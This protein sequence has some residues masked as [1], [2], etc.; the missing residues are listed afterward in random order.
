[1][2]TQLRS[3]EV[4]AA[5]RL[6]LS[7]LLGSMA[8]VELLSGIIQGYLVPLLPSLGEQ[9]DITSAGQARIYLLSQLAFAVWTPLL[10]KLGDAYGYRRLLRV[11]IAVVAAGSLLMA[12]WPNSATLA[13]GVVLQAAVVGFMPLLIGILRYQTPQRRRSGTGLL[14]G[15]LT[16]AVGLGGVFS[17]VLSEHTATLGLWVA[18]PVAVLA[19]A[20]GLLLP[21]G[22]PRQAGSMPWPAFLLM[23]LG[24]VGVVTA[25]SQGPSWGWASFGTVGSFVGGLVACAGWILVES[26]ART[27]LV[28]LRMLADPPVAIVSGVTFCLAFCTIGFFGANSVFLGSSPGQDGFGLSY[29]PLAIALVTLMLNVFAL[30]SSL[31]TA[32]LLRKLGERYTLAL[33][34]IV[35][36]TCFVSLLLWH[37]STTQYLVAIALLGIGFGGYQASTRT[38]CV[39][40]V[41]EKDTAMAAGINELALSLGSACGSAMVGAIMSAHESAGGMSVHAFTWLWSVLALVAIAG[42]GLGLRYRTREVIQ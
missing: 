31:S 6:P 41:P 39:E 32:R 36:A 17:G 11:S 10:A 15:V 35:I 1:M 34:G 30:G 9:L 37:Q 29:G 18:V 19:V 2:V 25:L 3:G 42:T 23:A 33:S 21:E 13:V 28:N 24:L 14:V 4:A 16:A 20:A 27:Q 5:R 12:S 7:V 22:A 40:C 8:V 38:L 26:R